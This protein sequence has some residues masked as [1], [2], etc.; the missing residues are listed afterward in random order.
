MHQSAER[1]D[2]REVAGAAA[3]LAAVCLLVLSL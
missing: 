2:P 3:L 1:I